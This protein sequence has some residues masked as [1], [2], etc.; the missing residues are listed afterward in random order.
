VP[1]DLE[2]V[3]LKCLNKEPGARYGSAAELA[4]DLERW[5]RAEPTQAQPMGP[6]GRLVKWVRRQPVLAGLGAALVVAVAVG[7]ALVTWKWLETEQAR[8]SADENL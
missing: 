3:C 4:D 2:A 8:E 6:A 7:F 1:R 5:L